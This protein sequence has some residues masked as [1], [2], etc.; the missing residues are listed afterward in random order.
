MRRPVRLVKRPYE[1]DAGTGRARLP[2]GA[3]K[4]APDAEKPV[5]ERDRRAVPDHRG[6]AVPGRS[7]NGRAGLTY[8]AYASGCANFRAFPSARHGSADIRAPGAP[9]RVRDPLARAP[10]AGAWSKA[11]AAAGRDEE[12]FQPPPHRP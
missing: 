6:S 4:M 10:I 2:A 5:M 8:A 9:Q 11:R 12:V 1:V 3:R 7:L